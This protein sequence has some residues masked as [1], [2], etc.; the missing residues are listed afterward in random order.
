MPN[1]CTL[2]GAGRGN[3]GLNVWGTKLLYDGAVAT[4]A[5][6]MGP[7]DG[8]AS[9]YVSIRDLSVYS[10]R[11]T[12]CPNNGML[13]WNPAAGGSNKWQ[14]NDG[15][16]FSAPQAHLAGIIHGSIDPNVLADGTFDS[17][18][19]VDINGGGTNFP[20]TVGAFHFGVYLNGCEECVLQHV[21]VDSA[22]DG[23]YVGEATNGVLF[24][25]VSGRINKR[26]GFT[27]RG[28][29]TFQC[30]SCLFESNGFDQVN[31]PTK[32]GAGIRMENASTGGAR[33][34]VFLEVC[35]E[36]NYVDLFA[37]A[38]SVGSLV[39]ASHSA[40]VNH[41]RGTFGYSYILGSC[42]ALNPS[43]V[44]VLANNQLALACS[45]TIGTFDLSDSGASVIFMDPQGLVVTKIIGPVGSGVKIAHY[46]L[47][48]ID[49]NLYLRTEGPFGTEGLRLENASAATAGNNTVSA[50]VQMKGSKW[51]GTATD[52]TWVWQAKAHAPNGA[53]ETTS[54]V[55]LDFNGT[56]QFGL[57]EGGV[58]Q[59]TQLQ[60]KTATL[61]AAV[62][63]A[64]GTSA[65]CTLDGA[66]SNMAGQL[67]LTT[68]TGSW[69]S[70]AQCIVTFASTLDGWVTLTPANAVAAAAMNSKQV[71]ADKASNQFRVAFGVAD[72]APVTYRFNWHAVG[73]Y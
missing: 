8:A 25:Q 41:M 26:A 4:A 53:P 39:A 69:S 19:N 13:A 49:Q 56:R 15:T 44:K 63:T 55:Y 42:Q 57:R 62:Q 11:S 24:N 65:S 23:F 58:L 27:F 17:I 52:Y 50:A 2:E 31:D 21:Y 72:T 18:I 12:T 61:T 28:S 38:G 30:N 45:N 73:V 36:G 54:G 7:N 40:G 10:N 37:A 46:E 6:V 59:T 67:T 5:I 66:S 34:G 68:G 47:N 3:S 35:F 48:P 33:G 20:S 14:C 51:T 22:D 43:L 70:G 29:N 71:Y 1:G 9:S 60:S 16:T 64:A 32:Y